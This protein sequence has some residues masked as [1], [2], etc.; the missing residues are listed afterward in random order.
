MREDFVD[1]IPCQHYRDAL[2]LLGSF[3]LINPAHFLFEHLLIEKQQRAQCLVLRRCRHISDP[4]Q[5]CEELRDLRYTH[6]LW[7]SQVMETN[8][9]LDPIAIRSFRAKTVMLQPQDI[10]RLIEELFGLAPRNSGRYRCQGHVF[11]F[12]DRPR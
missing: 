12:S 1:L 2:R 6:F 10:T 4:S 11:A 8:E 3:Y 5:M 7:M 9:A